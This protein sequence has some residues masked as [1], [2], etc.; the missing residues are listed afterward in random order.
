MRQDFEERLLGDDLDGLASRGELLR[1]ED[2]GTQC[3]AGTKG[4]WI[5][6]AHDDE[7]LALHLQSRTDSRVRTESTNRHEV[8]GLGHDPMVAPDTV[9]GSTPG[10]VRMPGR[11]IPQQPGSLS[12]ADVI[13]SLS[14]TP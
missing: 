2:L 10:R 3:G 6:P 7:G 4:G 13:H 9:S 8:R 14:F 1:L 5:E 11:C 12:I